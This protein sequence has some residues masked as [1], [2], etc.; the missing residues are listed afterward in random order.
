VYV[1][2]KVRMPMDPAN[3]N[4]IGLS[5][6]HLFNAVNASL[7]R[8]QTTWIDMLVLNGWDNSV[9]FYD[10]ARN[11]NDLVLVDKIRYLGVADFKG[12]QLQKLI[13][14]QK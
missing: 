5:R 10:T 9:S 14:V 4:S 11:L 3:I 12:W 6:S 2:T 7:Q 8:L 13:D 1:I